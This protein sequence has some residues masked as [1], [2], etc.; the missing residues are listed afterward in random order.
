MRFNFSL[1]AVTLLIAALT[2][3]QPATQAQYY[4]KNAATGE[5]GTK[6]NIGKDLGTL[7]NQ[8]HAF[9]SFSASDLNSAISMTSQ[10]DMGTLKAFASASGGIFSDGPN[11]YASGGS[12]NVG[13]GWGDILTITSTTLS[14]GT[15]VDILLTLDLDGSLAGN[16][17]DNFSLASPRIITS[18]NCYNTISG[19][20]ILQKDQQ[21]IFSPVH[22]Q[23]TYHTKV[24]DNLQIEQNLSILGSVVGQLG[25]NQKIGSFTA[26]FF[27]TG[28]GY[29]DILTPGASYTSA[30]G[31]SYLSPAAAPE[32]TTLSLLAFGGIATAL[33]RRK[34]KAG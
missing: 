33:A 17:L 7:A 23:A 10:S 8:I 28:H 4:V 34:R 24:G 6:F 13:A 20:I 22:L 31:T 1:L 29:I 19:Q 30:S 2:T 3:I 9:Q 16:N 11:T 26:D 5:V 21:N 14:I 18:L 27:H 32:P 12:L 25:L 15:P